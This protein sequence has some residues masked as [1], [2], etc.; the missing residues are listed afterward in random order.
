[1]PD[2]PGMRAISTAVAA[3]AE[4]PVPASGY[5]A[6]DYHRWHVG[7]YRIVYIVEPDV[8]TISRVDR[9]QR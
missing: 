4:Y 2:Q 9:A 7:D 6:G 1:M 5:H 8:I 3:L